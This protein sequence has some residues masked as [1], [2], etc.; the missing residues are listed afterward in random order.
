MSTAAPLRLW[1][2]GCGNMAGAMLRRWIESGVVASENVFVVNRHDRELPV[3]VRQGRAFPDE[4][5]P[6]FIQLG[7][8]PQ[9]LGD[10]PPLPAG[11]Y[12]LISILAGADVATLERRFPGKPGDAFHLNV[13]AQRC[14]SLNCRHAPEV[15]KCMAANVAPKL[16]SQ[17]SGR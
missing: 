5:A 15:V 14:I 17:T 9:Q 4:P 13:R 3:G 6:D 16:S 11:D 7:M 8:K 2:V 1:L 10:I 12:G